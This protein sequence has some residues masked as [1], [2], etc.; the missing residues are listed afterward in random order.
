MQPAEAWPPP[1]SPTHQQNTERGSYGPDAPPLTQGS[2]A[3]PQLLSVK[4]TKER[5]PYNHIS[6]KTIQVIS[7]PYSSGV[8]HVLGKVIMNGR[9]DR[10]L[11]HNHQRRVLSKQAKGNR[12]LKGDKW[13]E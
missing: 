6:P 4:L 9:P 8:F 3:C 11:E 2:L 1:Q 7:H 5:T 13:Q 10:K 12:K